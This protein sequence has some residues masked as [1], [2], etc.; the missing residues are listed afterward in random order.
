MHCHRQQKCS[1]LIDLN[2]LRVSNIEIIIK[3]AEYFSINIRT[4]EKTWQGEADDIRNRTI[5]STQTH[6]HIIFVIF[7]M[8]LCYI[9][10]HFVN[11]Q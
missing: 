2:C 9:S 10:M 1:I 7:T 11:D 5:R 4:V 3:M 6:S 8:N